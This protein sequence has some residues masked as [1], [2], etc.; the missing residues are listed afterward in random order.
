MMQ[1]YE[2]IYIIPVK[3]SGKEFEKIQNKIKE[4]IQKEGGQIAY[5]ENLGKKKFSYAIKRNSQGFYIINEFDIESDKIKSVN[6]KIKLMSEVI[7]HLVFKKKKITEE[8]RKKAKEKRERK[9]YKKIKMTEQFDIEKQ[10][11]DSNIKTETPKKIEENEKQTEQN[12][13]KI[14]AEQEKKEETEVKKLAFFRKKEEKKIK[15]EDLDEKLDT[16]INDN[17]I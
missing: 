10:L 7:R 9:E 5:E 8:E 2:L 14:E 4:V 15:L 3:F 11:E 12:E 13:E 1:Y 16:I 6:E 17:L